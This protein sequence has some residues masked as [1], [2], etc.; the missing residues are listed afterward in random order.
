MK[1]KPRRKVPRP[2][3]KAL[4]W[5]ERMEHEATKEMLRTLSI[6]V[7]DTLNACLEGEDGEAI[8][9]KDGGRT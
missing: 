1:A 3:Y 8:L 7:P 9:A 4:W 6:P 2:S 5:Q